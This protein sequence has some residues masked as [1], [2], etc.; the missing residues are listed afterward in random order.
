MS[1]QNVEAEINSMLTFLAGTGDGYM[2]GGIQSRGN[3]DF[4]IFGDVFLKAVYVVCECRSLLAPCPVRILTCVLQSTRAR[5]PSALPSATTRPYGY[6]DAMSTFH[7]L[8]TFV[9]ST[10]VGFLWIVDRTF[11]PCCDV[12]TLLLSSL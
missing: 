5:R 12:L 8:S 2:F 4:D 10:G 1:V 6:D 9:F 11:T 7:E 3:M